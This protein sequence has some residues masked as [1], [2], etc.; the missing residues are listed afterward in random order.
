MKPFDPVVASYLEYCRTIK[1]N[2]E[3]TI[4]DCRCTFG[5]FQ[6]FMMAEGIEDFI[7][8]LEISAFLRFINVLRQKQERGSGISKQLSHLRGFLDY[9]WRVG[10]CERNVLKGFE[11]RD[12]SPPYQARYLEEAEIKRLI[13]VCKK[14]SKIE[15]KERLIILVL[16]GLGL[17]TSELCNLTYKDLNLEKQEIL[18]KGKFDI[19]RTIPVPGGVWIELISYLQENGLRRGHVFR[20]D[21]KKVAYGVA[22]VGQV[23][24]K[25]VSLAGLSNDIT[26]KS[27]RHTFAC[28]LLDRGVDISV[29]STLMGHKSPAETNSYLHAFD[30]NKV[31]AISKVDKYLQE[32]EE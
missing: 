26:P 3:N 8:E 10:H 14:D 24:K 30:K 19:E 31:E 16:Y 22:G 20:T 18:V 7:W 2:H 4:K 27:L 17:R 15:R 12:S 9:C 29:I 1:K 28:H 5:K 13:E 21:V 6:H 11:L 32:E 23:I 25:Y